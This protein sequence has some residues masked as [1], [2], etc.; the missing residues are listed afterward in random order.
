MDR[1]LALSRLLEEFGQA[2]TLHP[3][4]GP[5]A[6]SRAFIRPI[7]AGE[8]EGW[9]SVPTPLGIEQTARFFYLGKPSDGLGGL[10][11]GGTVECGGVF[12]TVRR[13]WLVPGGPE[14]SHWQGELRLAPAEV[15]AGA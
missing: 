6:E 3:A 11:N 10:E 14:N 2:V 5:A 1:H 8:R 9:G 7:L 4:T 12:Y 13:A 15:G